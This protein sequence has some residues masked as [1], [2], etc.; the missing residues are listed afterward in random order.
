M[1]SGLGKLLVQV[2]EQTLLVECEVTQREHP[3]LRRGHLAAGTGS[4]PTLILR[5]SNSGIFISL[6][7]I[8]VGEADTP[9]QL[10]SSSETTAP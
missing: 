6:S 9:S 8:A 3:A 2:T 10:L 4:V 5:G 1:A 7:G